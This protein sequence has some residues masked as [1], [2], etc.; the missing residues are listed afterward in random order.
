MRLKAATP[1][2][3]FLTSA[4]QQRNKQRAEIRDIKAKYIALEHELLHKIE[5]GIQPKRAKKE[6]GYW[7]ALVEKM[8]PNDSVVLS[9]TYEYGGFRWAANRLGYRTSSEGIGIKKLRVWILE[10]KIEGGQP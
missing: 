2:N 7:I 8:V 1:E 5:K 10:K 6:Q 9:D 3:G 4:E